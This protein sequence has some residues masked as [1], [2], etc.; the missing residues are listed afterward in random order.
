[1]FCSF[2]SYPIPLD[3]QATHKKR[4]CIHLDEHTLSL[5]IRQQLSGEKHVQNVLSQFKMTQ[6]DQRSDL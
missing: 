3:C 6:A 4:L 1:M 5:L 2:I